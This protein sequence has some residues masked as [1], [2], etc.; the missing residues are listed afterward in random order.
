MLLKIDS[1]GTLLWQKSFGEEKYYMG[2][3][4]QETEDGNIIITG[5]T[6]N[7][8]LLMKTDSNGE[9]LWE[10]SIDYSLWDVGFSI[11]QTNDGGY[12]IGG[13]TAK[14]ISR[15]VGALIKTKSD[16]TVEWI[17]DFDRNKWGELYSVQQTNDGGYIF[18][19]SVRTGIFNSDVA[20]IKTN[21]EG[22]VPRNKAFFSPIQ[23][24]LARL[25]NFFP[26][27]NHI[28]ELFIKS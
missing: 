4:L 8:F 27:L 12:I 9:L 20:L 25:L 24:L 11:D 17:R 6:N 26:I 10:K 7:D 15:F 21:S 19:N 28:I 3:F 2:F 23:T 18:T 5:Q 14:R 13:G 22:V 1:D 16:G